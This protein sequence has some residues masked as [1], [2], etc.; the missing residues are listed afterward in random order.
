[1]SRATADKWLARDRTH[2]Q[3]GLA[4]PSS[5]PHR[6]PHAL[7]AAQV[8][9]AAPPGDEPAGPQRPGQRG[10]GPHQREHSGELVHLDVKK[11]GRLPEGG[12]HQLHGRTSTTPRG[13]GLGDDDSHSAVDDRSRVAFSQ[14]LADESAATAA[15][16]LIQAASFFADHGVVIQRVLTDNAKAYAESALFTEMA[17]GLGIRLRRTRPKPTARSSGSTRPCWRSG[18]RP[19]CTAAT[20]SGLVNNLDGNH[21]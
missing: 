14:I 19:G 16:F 12:G 7:P 1:V 9:A 21:T 13:R 6:C 3:A 15:L 11:L 20:T 10:G 2:G 8:W 4:D 5:R 18:P 17:A